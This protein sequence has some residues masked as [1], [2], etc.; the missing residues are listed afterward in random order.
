MIKSKSC[1]K[2]LIEQNINKLYAQYLK[3]IQF[4]IFKENRF[5]NVRR[6]LTELFY[7]INHKYINKLKLNESFNNYFF[8]NYCNFWYLKKFY[9]KIFKPIQRRIKIMYIKNI[10]CSHRF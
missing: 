9:C 5:V 1:E 8:N 6:C 2:F 7:L 3:V 4:S 10:S